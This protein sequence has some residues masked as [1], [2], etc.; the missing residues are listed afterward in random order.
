MKKKQKNSN[1]LIFLAFNVHCLV[2]PCEKGHENDAILYKVKKMHRSSGGAWRSNSGVLAEQSHS[3]RKSMI[4]RW[5][6]PLWLKLAGS[7]ESTIN[8][9]SFIIMNYNLILCLIFHY[10]EIIL[11]SS[12]NVHGFQFAWQS[13]NHVVF[14]NRKKSDGKN[15]CFYLIFSTVHVYC[16]D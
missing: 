13:F 8:Q 4:F 2:W 7:R 5:V 9:F 16:F 11:M 12:A 3:S 14:H 1:N 6:M 15:V 10:D